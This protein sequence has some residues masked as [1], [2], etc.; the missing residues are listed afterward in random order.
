MLKRLS[1][2][3][4]KTDG[5][6]QQ[7][8]DRVN[9]YYTRERRGSPFSAKGSHDP[10]RNTINIP[11]VGSPRGAIN[12]S[13]PPSCTKRHKIVAPKLQ[14]PKIS[15]GQKLGKPDAP[16]LK[17][18]VA[19]FGLFSFRL[20]HWF[21]SDDLR[22]PHDHA[23]DF[24]SILL[25]GTMWD[26]TPNE[27]GG[28]VPD[29]NGSGRKLKRRLT[30]EPT[31]FKANHRHSV[32]VGGDGAWSLLLTGPEYREWGFYLPKKGGKDKGKVRLIRRNKYF[33]RHGHH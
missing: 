24:W 18:W 8:T 2:L 4:T 16:Y 19:D 5:F 9:A 20:H 1:H 13:N 25:L 10:G 17:R 22:A 26:M 27:T 23:W 31:F 32:M 15:W 29:A 11:E 21:T 12:G 33:A 14:F 28:Y 30:L 6:K 3:W 7:V